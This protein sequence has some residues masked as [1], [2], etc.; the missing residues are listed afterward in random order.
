MKVMIVGACAVAVAAF[1]AF[2]ATGGTTM[3]VTSSVF[4]EGGMIPDKFSKDGQNLNPPLKIEGTPADAKSLLLIMDDPDAPVGL[5][6][7]WLVWNIDPKTTEVAEGS[8]P[9][10]AVQGTNDYP[11]IG[12]GGPQPPSGT[13]RYYFKIFAL[14]R[15]LDLESGAKRKEVDEAMRGHVVGQGE[16]MGRYSHKK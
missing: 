12:Y 9:S 13:H 8:V 11:N 3:K 10:G 7:H 15:L 5:F 2:A 16:L 14:D 6:T 4:K 1:A